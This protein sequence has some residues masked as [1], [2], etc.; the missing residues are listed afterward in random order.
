MP[1]RESCG[2]AVQ[3]YIMPFGP[4]STS[5][6]FVQCCSPKMVKIIDQA[7]APPGLTL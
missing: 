7:I 1:A 2:A 5:A 6:D 4:I 3:S